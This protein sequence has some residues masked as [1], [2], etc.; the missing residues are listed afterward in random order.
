MRN[1][2]LAG[3]IGRAICSGAL[4]CGAV[5]WLACGEL[6]SDKPADELSF[7]AP[8]DGLT[9]EQLAT[10]VAGDEAFN[11][12]FG[13]NEGLGPVFNAQACSSC[14]P[15]DGKSHP[16][17]NLVRFGRGDPGDA[18]RFDY[19]VE[20]GGPQLQDR[21]VPGSQPEILPPRVAVSERSGPIV[22]GLGLLEAVPAEVI[23]ALADPDDGDGDGISGRANFVMPP[24][25]VEVAADCFCVGCKPTGEGCK[26]LGRFGRK[27]TTVSL[28]HQTA[29]AYHDDMGITSDLFT[30]DVFNPVLGGPTGDTV[31]DPEVAA[32]TVAAVVFYLQTLRPPLRRD[33]GDARLATG[34]ALFRNI[35]CAECHVPALGAGHSAI[36]A[37]SQRTAFAYTDLLLHDM[38][39]ALADGFP[40]G[41]ATGSEW[42]TTPLWGLG[43]IGR[44]LGGSEYYLH[45]GRAT[46][47]ARAIE[48]HGGEA[49]LSADRFAG[50]SESERDAL[51][52][53][54]RSL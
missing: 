24:P 41:E 51:L 21:A 22:A 19:L 47:I 40:E 44:P 17:L 31:P 32:P 25:F 36:E 39:D 46:S 10:F 38:G 54:L 8:I 5:A 29:A 35:G 14:H 3:A 9:P 42:R 4:W 1:A 49:Q 6:L 28:L 26:L 34:E 12:S 50:L 45:D 37:I 52:V 20:L 48:L 11:D 7:D 2:H 43:I 13:P 23:I 30:Q 16:A 27:A 15:G 33:L 18:A 53:F